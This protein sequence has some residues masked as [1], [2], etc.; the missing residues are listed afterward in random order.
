MIKRSIQTILGKG[1][2]PEEVVKKA[3]DLLQNGRPLD[4]MII[5]LYGESRHSKHPL[6]IDIAKNYRNDMV[7]S[8]IYSGVRERLGSHIEQ[9]AYEHSSV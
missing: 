5:I 8:M 9:I 6:I 4:A 2:S 3:K 1:L 7:R